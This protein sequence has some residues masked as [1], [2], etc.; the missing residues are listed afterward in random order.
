VRPVCPTCR[1]A[2]RE[3]PPLE[4]GHVVREDDGDVV[5][6]VLVCPERMCRREQPIIDG[7]PI[8]VPE[9]SGYV[10]GQLAD[11]RA[12]DDL[13]PFTESLLGDCV[14]PGSELDRTRYQL[15]SYARG[16]WG[17]LDPD[18]RAPRDR[19]LVALIERA[20]AL[21]GAP[22]EGL[23]LD[24]GCSVGRATFEI[25]A[26]TDDLVL[27]LDLN[28]AMLKV[29]RRVAREGR[30]AH[31][32]RRVGLVYDRRDFSVELSPAARARVDFWACDAMALPLPAGIAR[33]A[34][35]LNLLDCM[36]SPH[37][38][39]AEL[40]RVLAEGAPALLATP[41]DWSTSATPVQHWLGGHSQ[42]ADH[43]GSSA[44][45][46]RRLLSDPAPL[47]LG[48]I[49]AD[50]VESVPWHVYVHERA[51]MEYAVHLVAARARAR[52]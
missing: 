36:T 41:Y 23:W 37:A 16:H 32:I 40:G 28:F 27:G 20:L 52:A 38:H 14:G 18:E 50:E 22:P 33:G 44:A 1:A 8:I 13:S 48:L 10:A 49:V 19:C 4:L 26:R 43:R 25:A 21:G 6:G 15:S 12:R 51:S 39:L 46:L 2:G 34:M 24:L 35:S 30:V 47:D 17:D 7:I 9:V 3:A 5:E 11:L 42:R 45:E 31:P 29:A